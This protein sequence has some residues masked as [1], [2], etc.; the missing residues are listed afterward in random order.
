MKVVAPHYS[1]S[2]FDITGESGGVHERGGAE[3]IAEGRAKLA[4]TSGVG[5]EGDGDAL[6]I[7]R[8]GGDEIG[9]TNAVQQADADAADVGLAGEG[10]DGDAH[11]HGFARG[12]GAV[13]GESVEGDVNLAVAAEMVHGR[14]VG[15]DQFEAIGGNAERA[16]ADAETIANGGAV[17]GAILNGEARMGDGVQDAGPLGNQRVVHLGQVVEG[18]EDDMIALG[19]LDGRLSGQGGEAPGGAGKAEEFFGVKGFG[20]GRV[21]FFVGEAPVDGV[22]AGG[23]GIAE[24]SDL[25]GSGLE[26]QDGEAAAGGVADQID[27]DVDAVFGDEPG[28]LGVIEAEE[29]MPLVG[30]GAEMFGDAVGLS[31]GGIAGDVE[32]AAIVAFEQRQ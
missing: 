17:G 6:V 28:G 26:R 27:E 16:K 3:A 22:E 25:N 15:G 2:G 29:G 30:A 8:V 19:R 4:A 1:V 13:V 14:G 9:K 12:G 24:I 11:P 18:A 20:A 5:G 10:D 31:V 23:A 32:L 7:G 21:G